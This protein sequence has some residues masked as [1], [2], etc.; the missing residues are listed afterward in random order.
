TRSFECL[1]ILFGKE[2]V[3]TVDQFLRR[4]GSV[5]SVCA[6][7]E[8]AGVDAFDTGGVGVGELFG[9][10]LG[11]AFGEVSDADG[12]TAFAAT[13]DQFVPL[14]FD[15]GAFVLVVEKDVALGGGHAEFA[16]GLIGDGGVDGAA[17]DEEESA[18]VKGVDHGG[19][20]L[21]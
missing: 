1:S 2:S 21:G 20:G 4:W 6:G 17:V 15:G 18:A 14:F 10:D 3:A 16:C 13:G 12:G 7:G 11:G 9:E 8:V 5:V 19:R